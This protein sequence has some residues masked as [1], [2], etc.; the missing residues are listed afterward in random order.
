MLTSVSM[1][2]CKY[3]LFRHFQKIHTNVLHKVYIETLYLLNSQ[4]I[5]DKPQN[6]DLEKYN[7]CIGGVCVWYIACC[8]IAIN[9]AC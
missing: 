1:V 6:S 2:G 5:M 8:D 7:F 3:L 4:F 9:I